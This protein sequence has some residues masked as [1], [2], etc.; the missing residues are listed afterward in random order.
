MSVFAT[1]LANAI[2]KINAFTTALK[3]RANKKVAKVANS[4]DALALGGQ[5][6]SQT[7]NTMLTK[8]Q[9]HVTSVNNPHAD[10]LT[11][12]NMYSKEDVTTMSQYAPELDTFPVTYFGDRT[13]LPL[14]IS[15]SFSGASDGYLIE[16]GLNI[17]DE[18][19][20][21]I[22]RNG[23]D[24]SKFRCYYAYVPSAKYGTIT[25]VIKTAIEFRPDTTPTGYT[26]GYVFGSGP[27]MICGRLIE[28]NTPTLGDYVI[29]LPNGSYA[30]KSMPMVRITPA[31]FPA[32]RQREG[33]VMGEYLYIFSLNT[34]TLTDSPIKLLVHRIKLTN[35]N[36]GTSV[37]EEVK[38]WTVTTNNRP[39]S[40]GSEIVLFEK[41]HSIVA[42]DDCIMYQNGI[43]GVYLTAA[44]IQ[45]YAPT[46]A[47]GKR[48]EEVLRIRFNSYTYMQQIVAAQSNGFGTTFSFVVDVKNKT[49]VFDPA[50]TGKETV[51]VNANGDN[52]FTWTN[53]G[54]FKYNKA[55]IAGGAGGAT[56]RDIMIHQ[57]K[58]YQ[59]VLLTDSNQDV[60][61]YI[62]RGKC[63]GNLDDTPFECVKFGVTVTPETLLSYQPQYGSAMGSKFYGIVPLSDHGMIV[64]A[65]G[66]RANGVVTR[67]TVKA[68]NDVTQPDYQHKTLVTTTYPG[69][70]P[71]T[72][73]KFIVDEITTGEVLRRYQH[74][75]S[76]VSDDGGYNVHGAYFTQGL[77]N[78]GFGSIDANGN[79]VTPNFRYRV[80]PVIYTT[81][82]NAMMAKYGLTAADVATSVIGV[83][84]PRSL[85][86]AYGYIA[87]QNNILKQT[88]YVSFE[89]VITA[90]TL[91][92][93][94]TGVEV[95]NWGPRITTATVGGTSV[96][97]AYSESSGGVVIYK[98]GEEGYAIGFVTKAVRYTVGGSGAHAVSF[99]VSNVNG[100]YK[101]EDSW[102][103][104]YMYTCYPTLASSPGFLA[105]KGYGFGQYVAFDRYTKALFTPYVKTK[106]GFVARTSNA[107]I[108]RIVATQELSGSWSVYITDAIEVFVNCVTYQAPVKTI[109][110][111]A[112]TADPSNK[113]F[114]CYLT[115][116][117]GSIDYLFSL[118]ELAESSELIKI[119][120]VVTGSGSITSINI[121][122]LSMLGGTPLDRIVLNKGK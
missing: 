9:Q 3:Q 38:D 21:I 88:Y 85:P 84:F 112:I 22:L 52:R 95:T 70:A 29:Y 72:N 87:W 68:F 11:A 46:L 93:A 120:T 105:L 50:G 113:T 67:N 92:T 58:G 17:E 100:E 79:E 8:H 19:S 81:I 6:F 24:G 25:K 15:G 86:R 4:D 98:V 109:D 115:I 83:F 33:V 117:N 107:T 77:D 23:T 31:N 90:G 42:T 55:N 59:H 27:N 101:V 103:G 89:F 35:F 45:H 60:I 97:N 74:L 91:E 57:Q 80:D 106:A 111:T 5:S 37:L 26:V 64:S 30:N 69:Y 99:F 20:A 16:N 44:N 96:A 82:K 41:M 51:T 65:T 108:R 49:V 53:S 121:N 39:T 104:H 56:T 7:K 78:T 63:V 13:S 75:V 1:S 110:L 102:P 18:G 43:G 32:A 122:K 10:K 54:Y 62:G 2:D 66:M 114:N 14:S 34:Y 119:G 48:D 71:T 73:R 28:E 47:I 61:A 94:V 76:E 118:S 116:A 12:I 40:T 36:G